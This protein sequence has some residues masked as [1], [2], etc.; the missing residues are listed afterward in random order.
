MVIQ[1]HVRDIHCHDN[2]VCGSRHTTDDS[3]VARH[4]RFY[5]FIVSTIEMRRQRLGAADRN[6]DKYQSCPQQQ[7]MVI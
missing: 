4:V 2:M 1:N 6:I 5:L 7:L 3:P